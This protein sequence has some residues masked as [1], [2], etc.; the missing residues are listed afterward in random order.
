MATQTANIAAV[1]PAAGADFVIEEQPMPVP[2]PGEILIRNRAI[3]L[4]P[5]DWKRRDR[6]FW[7]TYPAILGLDAA[8]EVAALGPDV[9]DF[10]VGDR[11]ASML[12][13]LAPFA[14][15]APP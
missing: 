10:K 5:I 1:V 4:N 6:N 2:G 14:S 8:G 13:G 3:A 15:R 12:D 9:K 11:V 7:I